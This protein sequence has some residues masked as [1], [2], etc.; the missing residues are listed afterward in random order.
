VRQ[1]KSCVKR[2]LLERQLEAAPEFIRNSS[3]SDEA[4]YALW[5]AEG[6]EEAKREIAS[7]PQLP[8]ERGEDDGTDRGMRTCVERLLKERGRRR[9]L[10]QQVRATLEGK[11]EQELAQEM[12][13]RFVIYDRK[14]DA[15]AI[16]ALAG[17]LAML[18][19]PEL[20]FL[21]QYAEHLEYYEAV[22][23]AIRSALAGG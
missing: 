18:T 10:E 15:D 3:L 21:V 14:K 20:V 16:A 23:K 1:N 19:K 6:D 5:G 13:R 7:W 9:E 4:K 11:S 22:A 8:L 2:Q 17:K 12:A